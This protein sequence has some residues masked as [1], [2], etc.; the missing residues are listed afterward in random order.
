[1][2][3]RDSHCLVCQGPVCATSQWWYKNR[4]SCTHSSAGGKFRQGRTQWREEELK[5]ISWFCAC[6]VKKVFGLLTKW[7][8]KATYRHDWMKCKHVKGKKYILLRVK[9]KTSKNYARTGR[10]GS[11]HSN[12]FVLVQRWTCLFYSRGRHSKPFHG[13]W[14]HLRERGSL[15]MMGLYWQGERRK[16]QSCQNIH[17]KDGWARKMCTETCRFPFR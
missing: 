1:M 13:I 16:T 14:K 3:Q 4:L 7:I 15:K 10:I 6:S 2:I 17:N 11:N 12:V 5:K 9:K 8:K